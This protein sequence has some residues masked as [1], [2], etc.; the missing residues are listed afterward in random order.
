MRVLIS[1]D[2]EIDDDT[3]EC[4]VLGMES[5]VL[6]PSDTLQQPCEQ[7]AT[8]IVSD[9]S[10]SNCSDSDNEANDLKEPSEKAL[11]ILRTSDEPA[12]TDNDNHSVDYQSDAQVPTNRSDSSRFSVENLIHTIQQDDSIFARKFWRPPMRVCEITNISETLRKN[13]AMSPR[14][15]LSIGMYGVSVNCVHSC[16]VHSTDGQSSRPQKT[17]NSKCPK[18]RRKEAKVCVIPRVF[19]IYPI[20]PS[21]HGCYCVNL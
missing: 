13:L 20:F 7:Y 16:D 14:E 10:N 1:E 9:K 2:S 6:S 21:V 15:P 18:Q 11:H 19:T 12:I 3:A 5:E 17:N 8:D 4:Y